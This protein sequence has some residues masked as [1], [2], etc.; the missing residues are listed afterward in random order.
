[1][2]RGISLGIGLMCFLLPACAQSART[3][4]AYY[5]EKA[6]SESPLIHDYQNQQLI[7][8]SELERLK[9]VYTRSR[10][11]MNGNYLFVPVV[12]NDN[13]TTSFKWN[14]QNAD[15]YYGYDLGISSGQLQIGATWTKPLLGKSLYRVTEQRMAVERQKLDNMMRLERHELERSVTEQYLLC[16]LD[17]S[18]LRMTES[19][20]SLLNIQYKLFLPLVRN[21]LS[22]QSD[23]KLLEIEQQTNANKRLEAKNSYNSHLTD[24][25]ILCGIPVSDTDIRLSTIHLARHFAPGSTSSFM[26]SYRLDSLVALAGY[27]EYTNQYKPQLNLFVDGGYRSQ[28]FASPYRRLGASAGLTFSWL[29]SDGKQKDLKHRQMLAQLNTISLYEDRH[30]LEL[31]ERRKQFADEL[32]MKERQLKTL[33]IQLADYNKLFANYQTQ[34]QI[35]QLSVIN[36]ISVLKDYVQQRQAYMEL[37]VNKEQLINSYNYWNW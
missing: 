11:E 9:S 20:D 5:L 30:R 18:N 4:L 22:K 6:V 32:T 23:L 37:S 10:F 35:G 3:D 14:A 1:M 13:G 28:T 7:T 36:Y 24:L 26:E 25:N 19:I 34:I 27:K 2:R 17:L 31:I 12:V 33:E 15:K 8:A 21:G 29:I 16:L